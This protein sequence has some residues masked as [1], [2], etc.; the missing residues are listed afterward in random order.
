MRL[1]KTYLIAIKE[2]H[3]PQFIQYTIFMGTFTFWIII[4]RYLQLQPFIKPS[5]V[6]FYSI[7]SPNLRYTYSKIIYLHTVQF[8]ICTIMQFL[9]KY[10]MGWVCIYFWGCFCLYFHKLYNRIV[11]PWNL[12]AIE[13]IIMSTL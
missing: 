5:T 8:E 7:R 11:F 4:I 13:E 3:L 1:P 9:D 2:F 12:L 10:I 6:L